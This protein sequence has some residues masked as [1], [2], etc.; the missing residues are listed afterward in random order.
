M[1]LAGPSRFPN[2]FS[3]AAPHPLARVAAEAL[4]HWLRAHWYG[5][6]ASGGGKMFGVL[7][8]EDRAG[9]RVELRA[10]SGV[11]GGRWEVEG[12]VPPV[13]DRA[14]REAV[15]IPGEAA[16]KGLLA[17]AETYAASEERIG[18]V[19]QRRVM[20]ERHERERAEVKARHEANRRDRHERRKAASDPHAIDQESRADKAALRRFEE[21]QA[22]EREAVERAWVKSERR[23]RA[24]ERLRHHV[25]RRL[26]QRIHDTYEIANA[27]GEKTGLRDLF[28]G[29]EPPSGAGDCAGTKLLSQAYRAGLR[30]LAMAEFWWGPPPLG[31]GRV[32]GANYPAC[33]A[34][35]GPLLPFML[36]GLEVEPLPERRARPP[37]GLRVVHEDAWLVVV[38]KPAGVLSV[39]GKGEA[40]RESLLGALQ[41]RFGTAFLAHRLDQD[42][43]GLVVAAK[44]ERT[45]KALQRLFEA[46]AV[47]KKYV[48]LLDGVVDRECG[49]ISF[50]MRV[51]VDDRPRQVY[52]PER[53]KPAETRFERIAAEG[54]VT[55]MALF[56]RTGRT[57]QLRVHASH[58][59]GLGTPIV[60]DPLYGRP[61]ARLMLH[62]AELAFVH[63]GTGERVRFSSVVPF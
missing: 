37:A 15:E 12:F 38:E 24:L 41:S 35:C 47:E 23:A 25:C 7:V 32:E 53:G 61:G 17:R 8:A 40:M 16:V 20:I 45:Y 14:R 3:E 62:A 43:S 11:L 57:H 1:T 29:R 33:K 13:F 30:P 36:R 63:P 39:P 50:P 56:P 27:A 34:K 28:P 18:A 21:R 4:Q 54:P 9:R 6:V 52:D 49:E 42:T 48:A 46:R 51:D 10:F 5:A 60:G 19:E 26:M 31:G 59:R 55:R 22:V 2:P 58:P 44:D